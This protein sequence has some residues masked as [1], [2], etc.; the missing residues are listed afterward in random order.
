MET[1]PYFKGA[2]WLLIAASAAAVAIARP[3]PSGALAEALPLTLILA[4]LAGMAARIASPD[5]RGRPIR[6]APSFVLAAFEVLPLVP[7]FAVLLVAIA[8][9]KGGGV[10]GPSRRGVRSAAAVATGTAIA[11]LLLAS[12]SIAPRPRSFGAFAALLALFAVL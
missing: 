1:T 6:V 3:V 2:P 11:A 8:G 10:A 12:A 4:A 9:G 5:E 7:A